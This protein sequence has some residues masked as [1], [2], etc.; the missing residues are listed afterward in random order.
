MFTYSWAEV[1]DSNDVRTGW[2]L[3]VWYNG[4]FVR[5]TL[6]EDPNL[7]PSDAI[8]DQWVAN[9]FNGAFA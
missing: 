5:D 7:V 8:A 2:T 1:K 6:Y 9:K 4:L 3:T